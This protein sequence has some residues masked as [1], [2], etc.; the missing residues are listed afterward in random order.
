MQGCSSTRKLLITAL[1]V[2]SC[3]V[4]ILSWGGSV[5]SAQELIDILHPGGLTECWVG[6]PNLVTIVSG[7]STTYWFRPAG[8]F[9]LATGPTGPVGGDPTRSG[10]ESEPFVS[11][12]YLDKNGYIGFTS[13]IQFSVDQTSEV[14]GVT[15]LLFDIYS[16]MNNVTPNA[17]PAALLNLWPTPLTQTSRGC[18]GTALIPLN[19]SNF[20]K[21]TLTAD[22]NYQLIG[23]ALM[24]EIVVTNT[25]ADSHLVG[26]HMILDGTFGG[27]IRDG[28]T[29]FLPTG[30]TVTNEAIF[31]GSAVPTGWLTY[32]DPT[33]PN[34]SVKGLVDSPEIRRPG[35]ATS[36]AGPPD[37][38]EF[39]L[40]SH[41]AGSGMNFI[42][43]VGL[44]LIGEDWATGLRWDEKLLMPGASRRYVTYIAYG[45]SKANYEPTWA[46][47]GYAPVKLYEQAG[48]DPSTPDVIEQFYFTDS[49]G[50]S[51]FPVAVYADNFGSSPLT[52]V[53]ASVTLP[54]GMILYPQDQS[55]TINMGTIVRNQTA[56]ATWTLN[57][58][59]ARPGLVTLGLT[60]PSGRDVSRQIQIP[61]VPVMVP[62]A[63]AN[64]LD[65]VSVPYA[66][67]NTDAE[68]VFQS[69][70][71]L[72][73]GQLGSLVRWDP[74]ALT[75][76]WFPNPFVTNITSGFG[77]WLLNKASTTIVLPADA[78]VLPENTVVNV[79]LKKGWNQIG[80]PFTLPLKLLDLQ[81]IMPE[82][83]ITMQEAIN[84]QVLQPALFAYDPSTGGYVWEDT[85]SNMYFQPYLG[86]WLLAYR[87]MTLVMTTPTGVVSSAVKPKAAAASGGWRARVQVSGGGLNASRIFGEAPGAQDGA[88]ANDVVAPPTPFG[89]VADA[90]FVTAQGDQKCVADIKAQDQAGKAWYLEVTTQKAATGLSLTWPDLSAVPANLVPVL[91]DTATGTACYMRTTARYRF[92]MVQPG[93]RLFR[94]VLRP[95]AESGPMISGVQAQARGGGS[96]AI[97][98]VLSASAAVDVQIRNIAGV[99]VKR[100]SAGSI[101]AAGTN[102]VLWDGRGEAG[103]RVPAGR[104]LCE[105]SARSPETGQSSSVITTFEVSR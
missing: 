44:S 69:L 53:T 36:S 104:Y 61:S 23:D 11:R 17:N 19:G 74:T 54:T 49:L 83:Q 103:S 21:G 34:L 96:Y 9:L 39:G 71:G 86:Y 52:G 8:R 98:Y 48:D 84:R 13:A 41:V 12:A 7:T 5:A 1:L 38:L 58:N 101:T 57:A 30:A 65:M 97:T 2:L 82:G 43:N 55:R 15:K 72:Q 62:R 105:L 25:T 67:A 40:Y 90:A 14:S 75:Y 33:N 66:F 47:L 100:V 88:D 4:L 87:D 93:S 79:E 102:T 76:R 56:G 10:D 85:L 37:A 35:Y 50:R 42:P 99:V 46:T 45:A 59:Q 51:P 81:V 70:G 20:E 94:I 26:M 22:H 80:D 92:D 3:G 78:T 60:G 68:H 77:Y 18:T 73:P 91:E 63:S 27:T 64:G 89:A 28:Q 24:I 95:K 29:I 31:R 32:D 6:Q 16:F